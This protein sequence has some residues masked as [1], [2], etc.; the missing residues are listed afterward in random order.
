MTGKADKPMTYKDEVTVAAV[1][2]HAAWGEKAA[3][4]AR[5]LAQAREAADRGAKIVL[6]PE[7]ALTGYNHDKGSIAMQQRDAEPVPGPATDALAAL[8]RERG[9]WIVVGL[10]ERDEATGTLYNSAVVTGPEGLVGCYRK[11]HPAGK[12]S[13]WCAKGEAP[14]LFD[15]P[16]GPVGVGICLDTYRF[17]E[18]VRYHAAQGA[19]LYLNPTALPLVPDWEALYYTTLNARVL[20]NSVFVASANLVGEDRDVSFP[21]GSMIIG[22]GT[23]T[24]KPLVHAGPVEGEEAMVI[25]TIDLAEGAR[26]RGWLPL[27]APNRVTGVP[28]WRPAVYSRLLGDVLASPNWRNSR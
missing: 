23:E 26:L 9:I 22:P 2:F 16:W 18:L 6:F 1:N 25:A 20:E 19:R 4:L 10:P 5:I 11:I 24:P 27:T 3:N 12:E 14:L 15:T 17:P 7:L 28:D 13:L 8:S 21:G